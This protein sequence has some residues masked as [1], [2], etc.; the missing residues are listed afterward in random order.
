MTVTVFCSS[1]CIS[2]GDYWSLG[3]FGIVLIVNFWF[4]IKGMRLA[5]KIK[6]FSAKQA[7]INAIEALILRDKQEGNEEALREHIKEAQKLAKELQE[8]VFTGDQ[9]QKK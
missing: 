4:N 3:I 7:E 1:L 8:M 5:L 9:K 6:R 2:G